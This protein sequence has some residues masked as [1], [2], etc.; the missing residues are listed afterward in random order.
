VNKQLRNN[1]DNKYN[2]DDDVDNDDDTK[3]YTLHSTMF[4]ACGFVL[5]G[6][7]I[8]IRFIWRHVP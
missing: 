4:R 5:V 2:Y 8:I 3:P 1:N 6:E 7:K